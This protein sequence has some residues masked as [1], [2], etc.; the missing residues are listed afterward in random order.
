MKN[1]N[2]I[3][4]VLILLM[5]IFISLPCAEGR[6]K[7]DLLATEQEV[8]APPMSIWQARKTVVTWLKNVSPVIDFGGFTHSGYNVKMHVDSIRISARSIDCE[9]DVS[10]WPDNKNARVESCLIDLQALGVLSVKT[11]HG[12]YVVRENGKYAQ[13]LLLYLYWVTSDDAQVFCNAI[14]RLRSAA[15]G[16]ESAEEKAMW[17]DFEQRASA[18]RA[19]PS[20]PAISEE[21]RAHRIVAEN[22]I[23]EKDFDTAMSEYEAGLAIDPIWPQGHFNAALI[24]AELGYYSV[25]IRH[26][27]AYLE[28][29]P[30]APDAQ[31]ARDQIVIWKA[32]LEK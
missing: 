9:A 3:H 16:E 15:R 12:Y 7:R 10:S 6:K 25:A 8:S 5:S 32:K 30:D 20:K 31:G 21:V 19:L 29:L 23:R 26:M 11:D 4:A 2:R 27:Q 14:N 24:S 22:A 28:L 17:S 1:K 13:N 18:Y